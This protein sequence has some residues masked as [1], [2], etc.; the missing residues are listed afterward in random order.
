MRTHCDQIDLVKFPRFFLRCLS[1]LMGV[2]LVLLVPFSTA[3]AAALPDDAPFKY[4]WSDSLEVGLPAYLARDRTK[5]IGFRLAIPEFWQGQLL[6]EEA[7][8]SL[9]FGG[10]DE[11][12]KETPAIK[13]MLAVF[14]MAKTDN[15]S[16]EAM[17]ETYR[18]TSIASQRLLY[19]FK[20]EQ[21]GHSYE[22]FHI[23]YP[24]QTSGKLIQEFAFFIETKHL[25]YRFG[26]LSPANQSAR[27][28]LF[29]W[30][31]FNSLELYD[32][33]LE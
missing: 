33:K 13:M 20:D 9:L 7:G 32:D 25:I 14:L 15:A 6:E 5:P 21:S 31:I 10:A 26:F 16:L 2:A 29:V 27:N 22:Y 24:E 12:S 3:Y 11:S 30:S 18:D 19:Q 23:E 17:T 1:K 28:E 8:Y 4:V